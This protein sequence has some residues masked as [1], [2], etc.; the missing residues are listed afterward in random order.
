MD[1]TDCPIEEPRPFST[2]WFSHKFKGAALKYEIGVDMDG[3]I[4]WISTPYRGGVNDKTIFKR[5][6]ESVIPVGYLAI[7]NQGYTAGPKLSIISEFDSEEVAI[8]KKQTLSRHETANKRLKDFACL[9]TEFRHG[10]D[11]HCFV[12]DAVA[13][14]CQYNITNGEPLF[15]I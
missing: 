1:G 2:T 4:V 14:I 15:A 10:V 8:F 3:N 6:L 9:T 12:F 11:M 5:G 13:T 7:A